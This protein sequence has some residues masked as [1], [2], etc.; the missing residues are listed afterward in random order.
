[1]YKNIQVL[2]TA[3]LKVIH[4]SRNNREFSYSFQ[5]VSTLEFFNIGVDEF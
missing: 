2:A 1:M 4:F 5:I 3:S